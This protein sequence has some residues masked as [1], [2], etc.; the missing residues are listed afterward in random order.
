MLLQINCNHY[1]LCWVQDSEEKPS[2]MQEATGSEIPAAEQISTSGDIQDIQTNTVSPVSRWAALLVQ[3]EATLQTAKDM[4]AAAV[5]CE[6]D[7]DKE[8][9]KAVQLRLAELGDIVGRLVP[10][11]PPPSTVTSIYGKVYQ[12]KKSWPNA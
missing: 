9:A 3:L 11:P 12:L 5:S 4:A 7:A 1:N 2:S 6:S 10:P 8:T